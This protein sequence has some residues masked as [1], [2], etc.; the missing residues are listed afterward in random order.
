MAAT[1]LLT[2][3][4]FERLPDEPGKAELLDGEL[5]RLPPAKFKHLEIVHRLADLLKAA[6][7]KPTAAVSLGRVY[8]EAGY[9]LSQRAWLQPDVSITHGDQAHGDFLEG[10]PALAVEVISEA[11]TAEEMDRKVKTY[12]AHGALEVWLVYP[13]TRCVWVFREGH[14]EEFRESLRSRV[15]E[16]LSVDLGALFS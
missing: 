6:I 4:D 8:I 15:A 3:E 14:A 12:L 9:K 1:T 16:G 13:K 5:I 2:F 10:A 11:N 7:N